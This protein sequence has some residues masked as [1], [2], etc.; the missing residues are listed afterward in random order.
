MQLDE[1]SV[2]HQWD[3]ENKS[4]WRVGVPASHHLAPS[5]Y[6]PEM[7][8]CGVTKGRGSISTDIA[9]RCDPYPNSVLLCLVA[10]EGWGCV[11]DDCCCSDAGGVLHTIYISWGN[12]CTQGSDSARNQRI[13]RARWADLVCLC[14]LVD[15][16]AR[17]SESKSN[18]ATSLCWNSFGVALNGIEGLVNKR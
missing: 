10:R 8:L 16:L 13:C 7:V 6:G 9:T 17:L 5:K 1:C 11:Q 4:H 18:L 2:L 12:L 3:C 15:Q 14:G